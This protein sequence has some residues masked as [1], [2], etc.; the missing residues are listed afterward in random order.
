MLEVV[1]IEVHRAVA[2]RTYLLMVRALVP[3]D[4]MVAA[5]SV[6]SEPGTQLTIGS[7]ESMGD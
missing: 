4:V 3:R 5:L 6:A 2:G 7:V 1:S